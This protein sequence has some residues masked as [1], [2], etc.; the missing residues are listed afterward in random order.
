MNRIRKCRQNKK[1]TLK[2][3]SEELA[4]QDFKIS[5]DA[6]GKYERGEREPKLETWVKLADFFGVSV[7]YLQ[8]ISNYINSET[9]PESFDDFLNSAASKVDTEGNAL[10]TEKDWRNFVTSFTSQEALNNFRKLYIAI[11]QLDVPI[12]KIKF[13]GI[14]KNIDSLAELNYI[15]ENVAY[16]YEILV[17]SLIYNDDKIK[18]AAKNI[19]KI[20]TD[21]YYDEDLNNESD[22]NK[23]ESKS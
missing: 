23:K 3:L 8:G 4:K 11:N 5:A 16:V 22:Q 12:N 15:T 2:Q 14:L 9:S 18:K 10:F 13:D 19:M 7:P 21:S 17:E 6:L 20:V 1:L